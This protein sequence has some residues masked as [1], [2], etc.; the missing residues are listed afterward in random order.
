MDAPKNLGVLV[1]RM[2]VV[3]NAV[4][5]EHAAALAI[6]LLSQYP[7]RQEALHGVAHFE[8][9]AGQRARAEA[10]VL[11][12]ASIGPRDADLLYD[13]ACARSLAGDVPHGLAY[14]EEAIAAGYRQWEWMDRDSDLAAVR[15][16]PGFAGLRQQAG[17]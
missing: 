7:D 15:A 2:V 17:R 8:F 14:L 13:L 3:S 4:K 10:L 12:A 11:A 1:A 6:T 16:D 5:S 9:A